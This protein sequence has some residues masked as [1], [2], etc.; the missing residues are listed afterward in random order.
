MIKV[1]K[2]NNEEVKP[3][4]VQID[5]RKVKGMDIS[6]EAYANIFL[7]AKK[8]SGKTSAIFHMLKEFAGKDTTIYAF[9]S[10]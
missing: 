9:V 2:V 3:V 7:C 5:T 8:K 10:T 6:T 4:Q 1:R